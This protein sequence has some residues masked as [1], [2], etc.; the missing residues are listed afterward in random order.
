VL[1]VLCDI[2]RTSVGW[3]L[4]LFLDPCGL[5][6]PYDRL[7]ALLRLERRAQRP[8]TEVLLNF[9]LEA[10][11]RI[12]GHV[13]SKRAMRPRDAGSTRLSAATGGVASSPAE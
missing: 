3:P 5:S 12:A 13:G 4:F 9:S 8:P 1:E 11:R 10:V 7:I 6:I 2:I